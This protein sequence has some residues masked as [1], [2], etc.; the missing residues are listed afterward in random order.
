M[1]H[2]LFWILLACPLKG[3]GQQTYSEIRVTALEE[4][5]EGVVV[6]AQSLGTSARQQAITD[7]TGKVSLS[8]PFP[9]VVQVSHLSY[10]TLTDTLYTARPFFTLQLSPASHSLN[11][12][13]VTGQYAPQSA[14]QSVYQVQS[15]SR[16][17]IERQG[18]V[19]VQEVLQQQ[20]NL[21]FGRDNATG[22]AN[23][24]LQGIGG[25]HVKVL[26]DG[27]PVIGRGGVNNEID[28]NQLN[29]ETVERIEIVEGPMA[30]NYGADALAGVINIITKKDSRDKLNLRLRL[31]EET[32]GTAYSLFEEGIHTP[33]V[34]ADLRLAPGWFMQ[35][36]GRL[37]RFGGW[38]G[39][40]DSRDREWYPKSQQQ[41]YGMLRQEGKSYELFYRFDYLDE[42]LE[43]LGPVNARNPLKDPSALDEEYHSQRLMQQLQ[44]TASLG[45]MRWH[46]SL[47]Y[48]NFRRTTR[49]FTRNLSTR[50]ETLTQP[51]EQDTLGYQ[52]LFLRSTL[53]DWV[54]SNTISTQAGLETR[55]ALGWGSRLSTGDKTLYELAG[56]ASAEIVV[57]EKLKI[58]PGLR[59]TYNSRYSSSPMGSVNLKYQANEHTGLR[60]SYG[61]GFRAPS[62]RELFHEFIDTNHHIIGNPELEPEYAHNVQASVAY[63][64]PD[65][66]LPVSLEAAG[67]YNHIRNRIILFTPTGPEQ[68]TTYTNLDEFQTV[69]GR[70]QLT[71]DKGSLNAKAGLAYTGRL[72]RLY[73]SYSGQVPRF[74]FSP[75]FNTQLQYAF[76]KR[77]LNLSA[78]YKFT[79]R[80]QNYWLQNDAN[81]NPQP[82]LGEISAFH[83]LD[84]SLS[85][86]W[87]AL[88]A[89]LGVKNLLDVRNL[90]NSGA[91]EGPHGGG[92]D[93]LGMAYGR[94][95]FL[96]F[97]YTLTL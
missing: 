84:L 57:A 28:L 17:A 41:Y 68:H 18:A 94:S 80:S 70:F 2:L 53:T 56:F 75:E 69:G 43:N 10:L 30:V 13:V 74:L 29:L 71:L 93:Q 7:E 54:K 89:Q 96:R 65:P 42:L 97:T 15:I 4:A 82:V 21:R 85:K 92:G 38:V 35:A 39:N 11:E 20:L 1:R 90:Q 49:E 33:S 52:E 83:W 36:G 76:S 16:E 72:Q 77:K 25:Q 40:K 22:T 51:D 45:Q 5:V 19:N 12:V 86:S 48:T 78:F 50:E 44:A 46:T 81:G 95:Y 87:N 34:S 32:I 67:F 58:R 55:Y 63:R 8:L 23:I 37:N 60:V 26:L 24:S 66:A 73:S 14:R 62:L 59:L 47:A 6:Q 88:D 64:M 79:G 31:H 9:L 91:A 27:V 3:F 61:R